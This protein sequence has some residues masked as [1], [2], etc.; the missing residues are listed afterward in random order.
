MKNYLLTFALVCLYVAASAQKSAEGGRAYELGIRTGASMNGLRNAEFVWKRQINE[1]KWRR[2][3]VGT[4]NLVS[5]PLG[6]GGTS[7]NS[8][9]AFGREKRYDL[10]TSNKWQW[11]K[12]RELLLGARQVGETSLLNFKPENIAFRAGFNGVLG[13]RYQFNPKVS[14]AG[15]ITPG[16]TVENRPF[17]DLGN[18]KVNV[19][20]IQP[21]LVLSYSPRG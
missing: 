10:G 11:Y 8:H 12:G 19:Q 14:F 17:H 9:L 13:V 1:H 16:F 7:A 18:Y 5:V 20:L 4:F 3:R 15:E 2:L 6:Y 21:R